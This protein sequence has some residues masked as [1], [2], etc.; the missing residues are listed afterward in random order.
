MSEPLAHVYELALRALDEQ[1]RQVVEL[2]SRLAPVLA[3]G[4][5]GITLLARPASKSGSAGGLIGTIAAIGAVL[6]VTVAV[7][8]ATRLLISRRLAFGVDAPS[9]I[10][11][12]ERRGVTDMRDFYAAMIAVFDERRHQNHVV[13]ERLQTTFTFMVCG[14]LAGVCG[15]ALAAAVA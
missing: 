15:L 1:E 10:D 4:G 9:A 2:R 8:A 11:I 14:M 5:L 6:G 12:I 13:I 7:V 3:A